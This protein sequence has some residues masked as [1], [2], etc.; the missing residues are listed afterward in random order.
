MLL[1][2]LYVHG[3]SI[4]VAIGGLAPEKIRALL[5]QGNS[6]VASWYIWLS[7]PP[8]RTNNVNEGEPNGGGRHIYTGLGIEEIAG[9]SKVEESQ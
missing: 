8:V 5:E 6:T 9:H 1:L 2:L 4:S 7:T 3:R